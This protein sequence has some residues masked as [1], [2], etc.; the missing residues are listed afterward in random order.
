[1][2]PRE[3]LR[4]GGVHEG[5]QVLFGHYEGEARI[6]THDRD[7]FLD[8][9]HEQAVAQWT[10]VIGKVFVQVFADPSRDRPPEPAAPLTGSLVALVPVHNETIDVAPAGLDRRHELRPRSTRDDLTDLASCTGPDYGL[11]LRP[12]NVGSHAGPIHA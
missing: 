1:M 5:T 9:V 8:G 10:F 7:L 11:M 4:R 12:R 2:Q 6:L 3:Y